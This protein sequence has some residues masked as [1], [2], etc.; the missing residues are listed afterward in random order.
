MNVVRAS[1]RVDVV[2]CRDC[3]H[4]MREEGEFPDGI[5]PLQDFYGDIDHVRRVPDD[6]FCADGERR[7]ANDDRG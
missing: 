7:D 5:C 1:K 4:R 2:R 6:W 3:K